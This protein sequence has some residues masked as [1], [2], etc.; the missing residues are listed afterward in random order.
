MAIGL[1]LGLTGKFQLYLFDLL[2]NYNVD[3]NKVYGMNTA[4]YSS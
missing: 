3:P 2:F 4:H 1:G